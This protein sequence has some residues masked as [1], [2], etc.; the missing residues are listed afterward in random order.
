MSFGTGLDSFHLERLKFIFPYV[1]GRILDVGSGDG[2]ITSALRAKGHDVVSIDPF[3]SVS[4][5]P[6]SLKTATLLGG[7]F[8]HPFDTIILSEVIEHGG[9][10][11][12]KESLSFLKKGGRIIVTAPQKNIL[13]YAFY[14]I[15][16][17][18]IFQKIPYGTHN[19]ESFIRLNDLKNYL[20]DCGI[21]IMDICGFNPIKRS[22]C[23]STLYH[24]LIYGIFY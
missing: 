16:G 22:L 8:N 2:L 11:M 7:V 21:K 9:I 10:D 24:Y 5:Y 13:S 1:T 4:D 19:Y 14:I 3:N 20:F 17:E 23:H 18:E 12:I 15:M 6:V